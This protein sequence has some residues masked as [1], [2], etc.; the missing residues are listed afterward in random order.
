MDLLRSVKVQGRPS[1][2]REVDMTGPDIE[3]ALFNEAMAADAYRV[4]PS[5]AN[6][7]LWD[8]ARRVV[9][10]LIEQVT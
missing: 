3:D 9:D 4:E 10:S 7:S 1:L 5:P 8:A 6:K 2:R